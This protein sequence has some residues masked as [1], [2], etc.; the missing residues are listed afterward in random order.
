VVDEEALSQV[1]QEG[2]LSGAAVD[3]FEQ[4]PYTGP[5]AKLDNVILTPHIGSYAVEARVNMEVQA[6][7][8]LI[9]GLKNA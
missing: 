2:W 4:E 3:V 6:V 5:L 7:K 1:L 8:N 9:E